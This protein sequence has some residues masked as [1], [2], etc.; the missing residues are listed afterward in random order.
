MG[1]AT[2][3]QQKQQQS[4]YPIDPTGARPG[5]FPSQTQANSM[6]SMAQS[7][8]YD[9]SCMTQGAACMPQSGY[10][11]MHQQQQQM[12]MSQ[13]SAMQMQYRSQQTYSTMQQMRMYGQQ[14]QRAML[15]HQQQQ[16]ANSAQSQPAA[17]YENGAMYPYG[18][19]TATQRT[20]GMP[21]MSAMGTGTM[22]AS[23]QMQRQMMIANGGG[24]MMMSPN[25]AC[26]PPHQSYPPR[27]R[28]PPSVSPAYPQGTTAVPGYPQGQSMMIR[29]GPPMLYSQLQHEMT[30]Q[31]VVAYSNPNAIMR[32]D[33][34]DPNLR[35]MPSSQPS[36]PNEAK[37]AIPVEIVLRQFCLD[38][39]ATTSDYGFTL[40][41]ER[42][43]SLRKGELDLQLKCFQHGDKKQLQQYNVWPTMPNRSTESSVKRLFKLN[44]NDA[45]CD[46]N[47]LQITIKGTFAKHQRAKPLKH[48]EYLGRKNPIRG[49][50]IALWIAKRK[51]YGL[52]GAQLPSD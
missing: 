29:A 25:G 33:P 1:S 47:Y 28:N 3:S 32:P 50:K 7:P 43:D 30:R 20:P 40:T 9:Q 46:S 13:G 17:I 27:V 48:S 6:A 4:A 49:R 51:I 39:N 21:G 35:C 36:F 5:S 23:T 34:S 14:Q 31:Q 24:M 18:I 26:M 45:R 11:I 16:L 52:A 12:M 37:M 15:L 22:C 44:G 38:H 42:F 19:P 2:V 41:Q 10:S 8:A